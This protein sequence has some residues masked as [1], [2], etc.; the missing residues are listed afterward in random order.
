[1]RIIVLLSSYVV[2]PIYPPGYN[3]SINLLTYLHS[4][5]KTGVASVDTQRRQQAHDQDVKNAVSILCRDQHVSRHW[6]DCC[7]K[8]NSFTFS[9]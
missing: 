9:L 6:H 1:L 3:N 5:L 2:C 7:T 8:T 4:C